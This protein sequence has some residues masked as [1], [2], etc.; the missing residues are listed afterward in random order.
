MLIWRCTSVRLAP[1]QP[2]HESGV[3]VC[4]RVCVFS[5]PILGN[6]ADGSRPHVSPWRAFTQDWWVRFYSSLSSL[7]PICSLSL[8]FLYSN[9]HCEHSSG[10][11]D[12]I[13]GWIRIFSN[14]SWICEVFNFSSIKI[15]PKGLNC[16]N[17]LC[18]SFSLCHNIIFALC[19]L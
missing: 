13:K 4:A 12:L 14:W 15:T 9:R 10:E 17:S 7:L 1:L 11:I 19:Y 18:L 8:P 2:T 5:G 3:R 16:K 6:T